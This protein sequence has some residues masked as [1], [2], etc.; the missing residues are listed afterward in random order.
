[1]PMHTAV[2]KTVYNRYLE[3]LLDQNNVGEFV[4]NVAIDN[5]NRAR[6]RLWG[7]DFWNDLMEH[8]TLTVDADRYATLPATYGKTYCVYHDQDGDNKPDWYYYNNGRYGR[9]YRR[10]A[11]YTGTA[12]KTFKFLFFRAPDHTPILLHQKILADFVAPIGT[13]AA[14]YIF[15]PEEL[16]LSEAQLL[17]K[18]DA[19]DTNDGNYDRMEKANRKLL[20]NYKRFSQFTNPD[21][22]FEANDAEGN[23]VE[24]ES[25]DMRGGGQGMSNLYDNS[26]D[27]GLL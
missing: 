26:H 20:N 4:S 12:A 23:R 13:T 27:N 8:Y 11:A 14:Q 10:E 21:F 1:M 19:D 2:V 17:H 24:N 15:F 5:I 9:G 22:V 16:L 6:Q 3:W 18:E 7:K 25:Y